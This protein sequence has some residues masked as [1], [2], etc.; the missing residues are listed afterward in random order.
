VPVGIG[1]PRHQAGAVTVPEAGN[2]PVEAEIA[3]LVAALNR[4]GIETLSSCQDIG[5]ADGDNGEE[6]GD[7]GVPG[8][9]SRASG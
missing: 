4:A 8:R 7:G 6:L 9:R 5:D 2:A 1:N 3:P